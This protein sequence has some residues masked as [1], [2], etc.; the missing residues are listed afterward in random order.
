MSGEPQPNESCSMAAQAAVEILA[1]EC[2]DSDFQVVALPREEMKD[3]SRQQLGLTGD[4]ADFDVQ[5]VMDEG[6]NSR[7]CT[8]YP[9]VQQLIFAMIWHEP[10]VEEYQQPLIDV[11]GGDL[12][13]ATE[14]AYRIHSDNCNQ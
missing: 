3:K 4:A 8:E 14:Q 9:F 11:F 6:F 12:A 13:A 10:P 7:R 2:P 1:E 5:A